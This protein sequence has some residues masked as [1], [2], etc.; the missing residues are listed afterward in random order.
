MEI[1]ERSRPNSSQLKT[2]LQIQKNNH[3]FPIFFIHL[4]YSG[5]I[6]PGPYQKWGNIGDFC[7]ST[8]R[9]WG[10]VARASQMQTAT[11]AGLVRLVRGSKVATLRRNQGVLIWQKGGK[12]LASAGT[13][14]GRLH[15]WRKAAFSFL[16]TPFFGGSEGKRNMRSY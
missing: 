16:S 14:Q 3:Y 1:L 11:S 10:H 13:R 5:T 7:L 12:S 6:K 4:Y 9:S 8:K 15:R 2:S